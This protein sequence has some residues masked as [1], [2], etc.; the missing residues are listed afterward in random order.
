MTLFVIVYGPLYATTTE[1]SHY[2]GNHLVHHTKSIYSL[3]LLGKN[4]KC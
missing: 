3:A 1:L 2:E 4:K